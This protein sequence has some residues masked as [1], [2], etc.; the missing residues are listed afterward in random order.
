VQH[1]RESKKRGE[2]SVRSVVKA[3]SKLNDRDL[4]LKHI[5]DWGRNSALRFKYIQQRK[6]GKKKSV[7]TDKG[8]VNSSRRSGGLAALRVNK[9]GTKEVDTSWIQRNEKPDKGRPRKKKFNWGDENMIKHFS[10]RARVDA[11][12]LGPLGH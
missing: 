8:V 9:G 10:H 2:V 12:A 4:G 1:Q 11:K 6:L 3:S 5:L 7:E